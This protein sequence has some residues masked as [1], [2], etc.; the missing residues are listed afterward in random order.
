MKREHVLSCN[1]SVWYPKFKNITIR[2]RV[3]PLSKEFVDYL[4]ADNV[5][6]PGQPVVTRD[7]DEEIESDS[8]EWQALDEDP[9]EHTITTPEFNEIDSAI[10]EAIIE[11]DGTVFPKLN[12]SSPLD[13]S[14]ISCD[15]TLKCKCPND[16]YLLLKSSDNICRTLF[17]TFKHCE[18]GEGALENGFELVLRKWKDINPGMEFRCFVK[19]H[20]L[21]AISQRDIA[22]CYEFIEQTE[23]DICSDIAN[24]FMGKIAY[25]FPDSSYT[26]DVYRSAGQKVLLIDFNPFGAQTDPLFFTW[27]E[28]SDPS[29]SVSDNDDEFKGVFKYVTSAGGVQPNASHLSRMPTDI[30]DLACGNDINKLV[31]LLNLR[32]LIGRSGDESD[33]DQ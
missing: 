17:E 15:G 20:K 26:F 28:L 21:I 8:E 19:D 31:D 23:Q 3:I 29:M 14:W 1:F 11:L 2:S 24:F 16:I 9:N 30:V 27:D 32:N 10:K 6:L 7:S 12:W 22:S 25:K 4:K 18:D 13:A 5:V 33:E